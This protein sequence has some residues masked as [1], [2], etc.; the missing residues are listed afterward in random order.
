MELSVYIKNICVFLL[1]T[2]KKLNFCY[3]QQVT[4]YDYDGF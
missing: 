3:F 1:C 4:N 2:C